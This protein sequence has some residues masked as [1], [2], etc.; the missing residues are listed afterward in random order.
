MPSYDYKCK[1]CGHIFEGQAK[2]NDPCPECP[3]PL[4][5]GVT[6]K[7]FI[8]AAPVHFQGGGWAASGYSKGG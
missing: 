8:K 2:M 1:K 3:Q 7:V 4:C 6:E 5:G